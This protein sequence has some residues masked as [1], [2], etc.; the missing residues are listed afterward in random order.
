[1]GPGFRLSR[2]LRL[3][4]R[5]QARPRFAESRDAGLGWPC[6]RWVLFWPLVLAGTPP[7]M[8]SGGVSFTAASP[9]AS[10]LTP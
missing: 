2:K 1:V 8:R 6:W 3:R 4:W 9:A 7:R 5:R 10:A